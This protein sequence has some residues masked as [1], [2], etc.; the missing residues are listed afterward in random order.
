MSEKNLNCQMRNGSREGKQRGMCHRTDQL[1][2]Q[3]KGRRKG[4]GRRCGEDSAKGNSKQGK[5][6]E[7]KKEQKMSTVE[8]LKDERKAI[9]SHI[10][11]VKNA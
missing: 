11:G 2:F 8:D 5:N 7:P 10:P 6:M 9:S 4:M 3:E 1:D